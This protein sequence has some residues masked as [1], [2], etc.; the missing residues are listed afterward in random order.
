VDA[1]SDLYSV[2]L[3]LYEMVTG[4]RAIQGDTAHSL[5]NAQLMKM[6]PEP[7]T[8]NPL[9]PRWISMVIMRALA[10]DPAQRFPSAMA[11]KEALADD[12]T[13]EYT[14]LRLKPPTP[15]LEPGVTTPGFTTPAVPGPTVAGTTVAAQTPPRTGHGATQTGTGTGPGT[16]PA[17]GPGTGPGTFDQATLDR[18]MQALATQLGPIA[19]VLVTRAARRAQSLN[20]LQEALAAE[21]P[22]PDDRRRFLA[23][24]R[25]PL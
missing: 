9:L 18:L 25:S 3:T 23:R 7:A 4:S 11:F 2:G 1:R 10:K 12:I 17:T 8:V 13:R 16:G 5:M 15:P 21:I 19:K 24:V 20:E 22:A 14:P 6:P